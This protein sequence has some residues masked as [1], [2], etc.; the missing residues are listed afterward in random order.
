M[1][2]I[3]KMCFFL[4]LLNLHKSH[5]YRK[6]QPIFIHARNDSGEARQKI[7]STCKRV[8]KGARLYLYGDDGT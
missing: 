7:L 5:H 4:L 2:I 6:G 8:K 1:W 3:D